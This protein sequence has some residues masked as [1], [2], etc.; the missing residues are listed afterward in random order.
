MGTAEQPASRVTR[1][2]P[3]L[4]RP[5]VAVRAGSAGAAAGATGGAAARVATASSHTGS[6]GCLL[7]AVG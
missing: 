1:P 3:W 7:L 2:G 4:L 6:A 5:H